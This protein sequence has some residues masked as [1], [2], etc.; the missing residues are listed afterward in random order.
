MPEDLQIEELKDQLREYGGWLEH[1]SNV[2]L[3][4]TERLVGVD[5]ASGDAEGGQPGPSGGG[6]LLIV[7]GTAVLIAGAAVLAVANRGDS[8][9][10]V[11]EATDD[12]VATEAATTE[13]AEETGPDVDGPRSV[14]D[15][16]ADPSADSGPGAQ[17]DEGAAE[18]DGT[19][20]AHLVDGQG[21]ADGP[22]S[23]GGEGSGDGDTEG[24][25]ATGNDTDQ[26]SDSPS[27][28]DGNPGNNSD[29]GSTP[30][31]PRPSVPVAG[32]S[33][34]TATTPTTQAGSNPAGKSMTFLSPRNG[35]AVDINLGTTFRVWPVDGAVSYT[36][37]ATQ[38]GAEA[39]R[40]TVDQPTFLLPGQLTAFNDG[41]RLESGV[42]SVTAVASDGA[43]REL[44][45]QTIDVLLRAGGGTPRRGLPEQIM[46]TIPED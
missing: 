4:N 38:N 41:W 13:A 12:G 44:A 20:E 8:N 37:I 23:G 39:F 5:G 36:F 43:G 2:P 14:L 42:L 35:N 21:S 31:A 17:T 26:T 33:P 29:S 40:L 45:S 24:Q 27:S 16:P 22:A 10:A 9:N 19:A 25:G 3:S 6:R 32:G 18:A 30:I 28:A 15:V 34:T 7:A 46:P 1:R 11:T